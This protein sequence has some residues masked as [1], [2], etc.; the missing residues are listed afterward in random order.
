VREMVDYPN[1]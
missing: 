1:W